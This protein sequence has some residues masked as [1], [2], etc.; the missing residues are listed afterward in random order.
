D[1]HGNVHALEK[2]IAELKQQE[3]DFMLC[4]GDVVGYGG[5]PN[6]CV[7]LLRENNVPTIAGNHDFAALNLVDITYFNDIAR[8]AIIWTREKL[9]P[10]NLEWLKELPLSVEMDEML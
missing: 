8:E 10:E 7:E 6:E 1:I 3:V 9:K 4:C 2:V 5:N